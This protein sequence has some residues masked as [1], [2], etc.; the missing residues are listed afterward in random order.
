MSDVS[1]PQLPSA[2]DQRWEE[3]LD[4]MSVPGW[5]GKY[6]LGCFAPRVTFLSQQVR[7]LNLV[8]ALCKAG[9]LSGRS[10]VAV[11]GAGLAG[12]TAAAGLAVRGV[13]VTLFEKGG[14]ERW[15]YIQRNSRQRFV[16]PHIY[17]WPA[18]GALEK[19]AGLPILD[20][21][22]NE[23][24]KVI[25]EIEKEWARLPR[26]ISGRIEW[27]KGGVQ[28]GA[29]GRLTGE[30]SP[31]DGFDA[32]IL[33]VGFGLEEGTGTKSY[34]TDDDIDGVEIEQ[35][36]GAW[37][38][39]GYGDGGLTDL[40]RLCIR[41]FR[42]GNHLYNFAR[43]V[44]PEVGNDLLAA[45]ANPGADF[46]EI[47]E[48]AAAKVVADFKLREKI[49]VDLNC[50]PKRLYAPGS[51][52]LNRL[53]TACLYQRKAF[54]IV[55]GR[56]R[57]PVEREGSRFKVV[58]EGNDD[59]PEQSAFYDGVIIRHGPKS[60]LERDFPGIWKAY[61][62]KRKIWEA[63]RRRQG[64]DWTR[65]PLF[66]NDEFKPEGGA[67]PPLRI[68]W[69]DEIGCLVVVPD[70]GSFL[71]TAY[72]DQALSRLSKRLA[73]QK[74][75]LASN[76]EVIEIQEAFASP[77][78]Y[79]RTLRALCA[80]E[81]AV[82]HIGG[83]DCAAVL[84]LGIRAAARRGITITVLSESLGDAAWAK[85]PFNLREIKPLSLAEGGAVFTRRLTDAIEAGFRKME[86]LPRDYL[87]LP[88]YEAVRNLGPRLEDYQPLPPTRQTLILSSFGEAYLQGPGDFVRSVIDTVCGDGVAIRIA[89][90]PSP[91]LVSQRL[92]EAI[93]RSQ[94]CV[95][96]WTEW[97]PNVFYEFGIR[98]AV[99]DIDPL[100]VLQPQWDPVPDAA[101][102]DRKGHAGT[103]DRFFHPQPY[104]EK[105]SAPLKEEIER[106]ASSITGNDPRGRQRGLLSPGFTYRIVRDAI[107][108]RQE[109]GST[110]VAQTLE[111]L[112]NG[113]ISRDP[114]QQGAL[115]PLYSDNQQLRRQLK[116]S[117]VEHLLAAW[118]YL[119][120]RHRLREK[121]KNEQ[122]QPDDPLTREFQRISERIF[123]M[124]ETWSGWEDVREEVEEVL[125]QLD[126]L[127]ELV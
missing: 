37:L 95:V 65:T 30:E 23:T 44:P 92:H 13:S 38:I 124:I 25:E 70:G 53:V 57:L 45:E 77:E 20:W 69:G 72:V 96:D 85:L 111:D 31:L 21:E 27:G 94:F 116:V 58:F 97:K 3:L 10:R 87:D 75:K 62:P 119:D 103:L 49:K 55:P 115:P 104:S 79:A 50:D 64:V 16:H 36:A 9:I 105:T 66:N 7:A 122:L 18:E 60:A 32:V 107:D 98:L 54:R 35:K 74:R 114:F 121:L 113:M 17:D 93:R 112:A 78:R 89:E 14:E 33:A 51:S 73:G 71:A 48:E 2:E 68:D 59:T 47:Y 76:S 22:A 24:S 8:D 28:S 43:S 117:A 52:I 29:D 81:I 82:F 56:V 101:L 127:G 91:Q 126:E 106:Y 83:Y 110:L 11:V 6:V 5:P 4:L 99:C 41:D 34:W 1:F 46:R 125:S 118:Y 26:E 90:T 80:A 120:R 42:Q 61:E 63:A 84:L 88:S 39:S 15:M 108:I 86:S 19:R 100:C 123:G 102:R 40:M 12:F 109:P 67:V